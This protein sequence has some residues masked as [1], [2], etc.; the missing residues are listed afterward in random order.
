MRKEYYDQYTDISAI[1][2]IASM[3][4]DDN[5]AFQFLYSINC[6]SA[7]CFFEVNLERF[8]TKV[9]EFFDY[10]I[11]IDFMIA[12][13]IKFMDV[14]MTYNRKIVDTKLDQTFERA[15]LIPNGFNKMS[16]TGNIEMTKVQEKNLLL[17]FSSGESK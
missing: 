16:L 15:I 9:N 3:K 8:T 12:H 5:L 11:K 2:S 4:M 10:E 6:L 13:E 7:Q 1:A 14:N 17:Q